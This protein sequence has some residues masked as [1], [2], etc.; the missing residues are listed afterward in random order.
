M[1]GPTLQVE[2]MTLSYLN[3][4]ADFGVIEIVKDKAK[5]YFLWYKITDEKSVQPVGFWQRMSP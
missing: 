4:V 1:L 5:G 2:N 3:E